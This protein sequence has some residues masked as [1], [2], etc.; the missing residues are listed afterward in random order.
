M[1]NS[2]DTNLC[3]HAN[4][5]SRRGLSIAFGLFVLHIMQFPERNI[6]AVAGSLFTLFDRFLDSM[7][8]LVNSLLVASTRTHAGLTP[9]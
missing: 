1:C 3:T 4:D 2:T 6:S 5:F 9:E 8:E 7:P